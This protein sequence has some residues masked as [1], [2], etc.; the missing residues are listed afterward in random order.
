MF[1]KLAMK[2]NKLLEFGLLVAMLFACSPEP[3]KNTEGG[4]IPV[5]QTEIPFEKESEVLQWYMQKTFQTQ[6]AKDQ[7]LYIIVPRYACKG[8]E[9]T[10]LKKIDE[11]LPKQARNVSLITDIPKIIPTSLK[12]NV[13]FLADSTGLLDRVNLPISNVTIVKTQDGNIEEFQS[14]NPKQLP[15]MDSILAHFFLGELFAQEQSGI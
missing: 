4:N 12:E 10:S 15:K 6:V 5:L 8:C 11:L 3:G 2:T 14:L 1:S 7:H 9:N 13:N